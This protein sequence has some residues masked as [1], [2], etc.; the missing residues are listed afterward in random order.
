MSVNIDHVLYVSITLY[1]IFMMG[2]M[3]I[4]PRL[5]FNDQTKHL[6]NFGFDDDETLF[7]LPLLGTLLSICIYMVIMTYNVLT[8]KFD[9]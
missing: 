7:S 8:I 9:K 3:L 2:I 6:R 1:I 4:K 5:M